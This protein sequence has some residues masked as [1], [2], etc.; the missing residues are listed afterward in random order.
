MK[1]EKL[2]AKGNRMSFTI[3][4]T[5]TA[6]ANALRRTMMME[7][8]VMAVDEIDFFENSSGLFDEFIGHRIGL[9]PLTTN[10]KTYKLPEDCDGGKCNKCSAIAE[11]E[12]E[13]PATVYSKDLKFETGKVKVVEDKVPIMILAEGQKLRLEAKSLLG[14]GRKH[15]KHQACI[16]TY[17]LKK[18]TKNKKTFEF[19]VESYG[20]LAPKEILKEALAILEDKVKDLGKQL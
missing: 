2:K 6:M 10:L 13:G 16:C 7:I 14:I 1:I 3:E 4:G 18:E 15:A 11:L 5:T 9:I 17:K 19:E 20:S 12:V 8:P